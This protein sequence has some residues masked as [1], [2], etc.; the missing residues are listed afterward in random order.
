MSTDVQIRLKMAAALLAGAGAI[1]GGIWYAG[2][3]APPLSVRRPAAQPASAAKE[4][5]RLPATMSDQPA[6]ARGP[7]PE[8][9]I[10]R[11]S[12]GELPEPSAPP[13][14][15]VIERA[16]RG[17]VR[18]ETQTSRG[19]GFFVRP[20]LIV[21]N[22]HVISGFAAVSVTTQ[23]GARLPGRVAQISDEADVALVQVGL[24]GSPDAELPLGTSAA[25]RLGQGIVAL[26]WA[27]SIEQRTLARG[28]V[29]GL[30]RVLDRPFLQTDAAPNPGDSGGPVMNRQG[31]VIGIT[32]LRAT[33]GS[34]G[35]AVPIDDAKPLLARA[36]PGVMTLPFAGAGAAAPGAAGPGGAPAAP[37]ASGEGAARPNDA[38]VQRETGGQQYATTLGGTAHRAADLDEAWN[39]YRASCHITDVRAGD[40]HEWFQLY[41]PRSPLH[42]TAAYCASALNA[43]QHEADAINAAM[44]GADEAARRADVYP[45]AR[46]EMRRRFRLDYEGWDR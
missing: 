39:R 2:P 11:A 32:T 44:L 42:R 14:E 19:S 1:A 23:N 28:I 25:L 37:A 15:D 29:T 4:I 43:V 9:P 13:L 3:K 36:G 5:I 38:G 12:S 41:D 10:T 34:A 8:A 46:R 31:E 20:D 21:T 6:A 40:S 35:Y 27:E 26:G 33:D 22:A 24:P 16:M 17:V 7:A 18:I 45:G 30:R